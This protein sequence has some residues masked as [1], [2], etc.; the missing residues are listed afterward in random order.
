[1]CYECYV[2]L[3]G[4]HVCADGDQVA[5]VHSRMAE[6]QTYPWPGSVRMQSAA[7][8]GEGTRERGAPAGH[9]DGARLSSAQAAAPHAPEPRGRSPDE[10]RESPRKR[11]EGAGER[12]EAPRSMHARPYSNTFLGVHAWLPFMAAFLTLHILASASSASYP[13]ISTAAPHQPCQG[14][15]VSWVVPTANRLRHNWAYLPLLCSY[16]ALPSA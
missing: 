13:A 11:C 5:K 14:G 7:V 6:H 15:S 2:Q 4:L 9:S 8:Q 12:G 10:C 16:S 3:L 1:M